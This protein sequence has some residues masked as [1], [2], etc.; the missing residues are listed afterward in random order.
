M[1]VH[2][3]WH[4]SWCWRPLCEE[5]EQRGHDTLAVDLPCETVGLS[6]Q[7]CAAAVGAHPDAVVV[8]HSMG[9]LTIPL[10]E[11]RAW[12]FLAA[13]VPA[14]VDEQALDPGFTGT[15]RDELGRSYWPEES[16]CREKLYPDLSDEDAAW[17][18]S[19]LRRTI[20]L[21]TAATGQPA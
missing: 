9:G 15:A 14:D 5:L 18:F 7:D 17:A 1:L 2:G 13:L 21:D 6:V 4:G 16:I 20:W 8:G 19:L 10:V 3:A 11:A 12:V